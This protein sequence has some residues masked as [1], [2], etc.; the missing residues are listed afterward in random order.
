MIERADLITTRAATHTAQ[1]RAARAYAG[2]GPGVMAKLVPGDDSLGNGR[3]TLRLWDAGHDA[4]RLAGFDILYLELAAIG[5]GID[6]RYIEGLA[7]GLGRLGQQA[8]IT[9]LV[10]D[11]LLRNQS[12]LGIDRD[13]DGATHPDAATGV[14]R[15]RVRIGQRDLAP[16]TSPAIQLICG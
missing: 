9:D 10:V 5:H 4:C 13:P 14:H 1:S 3:S 11:L 8:R 12:V 7:G 15:T 16:A 6:L 2:I